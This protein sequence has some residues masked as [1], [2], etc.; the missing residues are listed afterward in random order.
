M[1][2]VVARVSNGPEAALEMFNPSWESALTFFGHV[3]RRRSSRNSST[4]KGQRLHSGGTSK[5][6]FAM[7]V[8][9]TSLQVHWVARHVITGCLLMLNTHRVRNPVGTERLCLA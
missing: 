8:A 7:L 2:A 6:G 3:T 4:T 9:G 1:T 5:C